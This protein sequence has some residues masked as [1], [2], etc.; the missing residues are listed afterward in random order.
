MTCPCGYYSTCTATCTTERREWVIGGKVVARSI[1][2]Q[3]LA[4]HQKDSDEAKEEL[5]K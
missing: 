2:E 3:L 5:Y 4:E 1:R